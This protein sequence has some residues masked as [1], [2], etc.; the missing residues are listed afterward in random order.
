VQK[1]IQ[2]QRSEKRRQTLY[3]HKKSEINTETYEYILLATFHK[4]NK[5]Q[6]SKNKHP[7]NNDKTV[8]MEK[9]KL[10]N[11]YTSKQEITTTIKLKHSKNC[12]TKTQEMNQF[13][14]IQM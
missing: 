14:K 10:T 9:K 7:P 11:N 5:I 4:T 13:Q 12:E 1:N 8:G 3:L 2:T 6:G